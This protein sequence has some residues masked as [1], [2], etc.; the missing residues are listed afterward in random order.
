[1]V[2]WFLRQAKSELIELADFT[3]DE[4]HLNRLDELVSIVSQ[5]IIQNVK[6]PKQV[7]RKRR[8]DDMRKT[9][10]KLH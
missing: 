7:C 3:N 5:L 9:L 4:C 10:Q 2:E 1:M 8:I 6:S